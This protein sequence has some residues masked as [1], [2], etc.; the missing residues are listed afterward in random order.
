MK[1]EVGK[2]WVGGER[3]GKGEFDFGVEAVE[4]VQCGIGKMLFF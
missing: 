2:G 3:E 4:R 1:K